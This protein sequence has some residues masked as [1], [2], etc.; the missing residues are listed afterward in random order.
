MEGLRDW[1][2]LRAGG[3]G[4]IWGAP[5]AHPASGRCGAAARAG[6]PSRTVEAFEARARRAF[7]R[8]D[9]EGGGRLSREGVKLAFM[10]LLG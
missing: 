5:S 3:H 1:H 9:E 2:A 6:A 8:Y 7:E 4:A 10:E